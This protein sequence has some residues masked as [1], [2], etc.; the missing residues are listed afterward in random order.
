MSRNWKKVFVWLF[1]WT[2]FYTYTITI[3]KFIYRIKFNVCANAC[4]SETRPSFLLQNE[5][6]LLYMM[7]EIRPICQRKT[8][9][10]GIWKMYKSDLLNFNSNEPLLEFFK[11]NW[12]I[13]KC[14]EELF[15][16]TS[17]NYILPR[18]LVSRSMRFKYCLK[19]E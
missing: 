9:L 11:W 12:A 7:K 16:D 17:K 15:M 18:W 8:L 14:K 13:L 5:V 10:T 1:C 6:K 4:L 3:I 19:S 2:Y